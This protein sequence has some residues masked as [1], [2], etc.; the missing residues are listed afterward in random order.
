[1]RNSKFR[2]ITNHKLLIAHVIYLDSQIVHIDSDVV[3]CATID[4]P[5]VIC[6]VRGE[7]NI[8]LITSQINT[9]KANIKPFVAFNNHM[10]NLATKLTDWLVAMTRTTIVKAM[11]TTEMRVTTMIGI[12]QYNKKR[13]AISNISR[14]RILQISWQKDQLML[15][16]HFMS[17]YDKLN[18]LKSESIVSWSKINNDWLIFRIKSN[19]NIKNKIF[20]NNDLTNIVKI[21]SQTSHLKNIL[22]Y[23][24]SSFLQC[25]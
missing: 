11:M 22:L 16:H 10:T 18:L 4:I 2:T 23:T 20:I 8:C 6:K 1:M 24:K 3:C 19:K 17:L 21:V 5:L 13:S 9:W 7:S 25:L 12:T 14:G 15:N